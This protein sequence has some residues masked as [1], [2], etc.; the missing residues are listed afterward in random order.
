MAL[1][2]LKDKEKAIQLRL[3]GM[4]YSQIKEKLNLSKSTL[5]NWLAPYPLSAQRISEL[6][7]W[8]SKR[9]EN[10]RATMQNKREQK[11]L[12]VYEKVS[13]DI[14]KLSKRELFIGGLL[15][16]WG[17]G[18]KT[19]N[20]TVALSNTD[21]S[22][23]RFF[24]QWLKLFE[25]K[26][27]ELSIVMHLYK[28][29][30][31]SREIKFWMK[32]LNLPKSCFRKSYVKESNLSNLSYKSGFGHGT[33]NIRIYGKKLYDYILMGIKYIGDVQYRNYRVK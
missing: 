21:P 18:A 4:S 16:Y 6:R 28:D 1:R 32:Q 2:C 17:E 19:S 30:D 25:I 11:L 14:G 26:E 5:S 12:A 7:D 13:K 9:I 15:L 22:V 31:E 29:M 23:L 8:S 24:L 27:S 10:Y 33:C 3:R 20:A